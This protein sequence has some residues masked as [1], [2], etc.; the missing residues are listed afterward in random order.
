MAFKESAVVPLALHLV[1]RSSK[2]I[3]Y[4]SKECRR[5]ARQ[6]VKLISVR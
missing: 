1:D 5:K 4:V 6:G 2:A 3:H